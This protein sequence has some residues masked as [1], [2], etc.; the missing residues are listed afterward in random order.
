MPVLLEK[1]MEMKNDMD[2]CVNTDRIDIYQSDAVILDDPLYFS[3]C[4]WGSRV[5]PTAFYL[6][7][8][9]N[10]SIDF[11]GARLILHGKIQPFT[12]DECENVTIRNVAVEYARSP[13][14]EFRIISNS[15]NKMRMKR[16]PRFECKI[17]NGSIV[18][19]GDDWENR[20]LNCGNMFMQVFDSETGEG[21]GLLVCVIGDD[22]VESSTPPAFVHRYKAVEEEGDVVLSGDFPDY[23]DSSMTAVLAH[24]GRDVS[25]IQICRS[26]NICIENYRII[27]GQGM[28]I[29]GM[30]NE[31]IYI[32]GLRLTRDEISH[33]I[34]TN[35]A[36]AVHLVA[37][38]GQISI[39]DSIFEGMI[40]DALNV[41]SVYLEAEKISGDRV[42]LLCHPERHMIR[43]NFKI[44]D[45]GDSILIHTGNTMEEKGKAVV[46]SYDIIDADHIDIEID[47]ATGVERGDYFE[48]L[49]TQP[50]LTIRNCVFRKANSHL[51]IQT[52]GKTVISKCDISLPLM[53]TGDTNYWQESSPVND[54]TITGC[55]FHGDRGYI[56]IC[57]EFD[58]VEKAPYYHRNICVSDSVFEREIIMEAFAADNIRVDSC[59]SSEGVPCLKLKDC[60]TVFT[61]YKIIK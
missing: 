42:R 48:N 36:D 59:R 61:P 31:G 5:I 7:G 14:T 6:R 11:H 44:L 40:D 3:F 4:G 49:S 8:L 55:N 12:I 15:H 52:R 2:Y 43:A 45:V 37:T 17:E 23:W 46:K 27:N 51:R 53:L 22:I 41:H 29:Q 35:G 54:I 39:D 21:R 24:E 33:G 1:K 9:K 13:Y 60:G 38:K 34:V 57:P 47:K 56:R 25:S 28:G 19:Y 20:N 18:P 16:L 26:K 10:V 58:N 30:Y 50:E 32:S